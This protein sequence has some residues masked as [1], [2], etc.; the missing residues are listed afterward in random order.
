MSGIQQCTRCVWSVA[1]DP[2]LVIA[3]NGLC[4]HCNRYDQ[5]LSTRVQVGGLD[6][7]VKR[8][9]ADGRDSEYDCIV[10][11]SGGVDSS[12]VALMAS[13][14]GLRALAI[15]FDNGWNSELAV[16]NVERL[17]R[18]T[19]FDLYTYVV[20]WHQFR[21]LQRAFFRASTPDVEVVTDHGITACL[22]QQARQRKIPYILSG[23]NFATESGSVPHWAY[24]HSDWRYIKAV[25]RRFGDLKEV[26]SF[27]R[28]RS[29]KWDSIV[30][31][32]ES[33]Q[34]DS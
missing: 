24:G 17:L 1:R 23:M 2:L 12:F 34:L 21:D 14:L 33:K 9:K 13:E 26:D 25:H 11:V 4:Q 27:P 28:L 7:M 22:Q 30:F 10:G 20:E 6:E 3:E 15:H 31:S 29:E 8:I 16:G 19:G 18:A 32:V 5:Q